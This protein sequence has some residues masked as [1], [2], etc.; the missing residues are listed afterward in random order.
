MQNEY[1]M[2]AD[3]NTNANESS[4][5]GMSDDFQLEQS[6][7]MFHCVLTSPFVLLR[8]LLQ[9]KSKCKMKKRIER[10][11]ITRIKTK[12]EEGMTQEEDE[13]NKQ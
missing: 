6:N 3:M 1:N 11:E 10:S 7:F 4:C 8:R 13:D 9:T 12:C 5:H 2:H